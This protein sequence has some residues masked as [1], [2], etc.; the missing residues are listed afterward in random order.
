MHSTILYI[1]WPEIVEYNIALHYFPLS[2]LTRKLHSTFRVNF[3]TDIAL[4]ISC[5]L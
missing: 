2:L 4:H 1:K 5:Q 3:D